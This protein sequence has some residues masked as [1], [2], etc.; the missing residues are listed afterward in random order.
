MMM[1]DNITLL[2]FLSL[3]LTLSLGQGRRRKE[4]PISD[5]VSPHLEVG[6]E[7]PKAAECRFGG[8]SYE[9]E[10]TWH[11]DLGPPFNVM[12]CVHCECVPIHKKRRIVGRVRCKNIKTECPKPTC[13]NPILL[14]GRCCKVCPG[15]NDNPDLT[16]TVD[17]EREE[18]EKNGRHYATVLT[19]QGVS[20]AATGRFYFRKKT[21]Q[22]SFLFG[23]QLGWPGQLSFLDGDLNI[24]EDFNL[25]QTSLQNQTDKLCGAW[26]R[27]PRKYRRLLRSEELSIS[28]STKYGL[29]QGKI[30]K[31]YG[32]NS[33][34]FSGLFEG[35]Y[36]SGTAIVSVSPGTGSIHA[37]I[38]FKGIAKEG[39]ENVKFIVRFHT[40]GRGTDTGPE[41]SVEESVVL[42]SVSSE[43]SSVEVRTV[44]DTPE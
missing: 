39:E 38:L 13:P 25:S 44:F 20:T 36:G 43:L 6:N 16:I 22:Y 37:N 30:K 4:L 10:Q 12:Y 18:Q 27:L 11:P 21:L 3:T 5:A 31:Y 32:L 41:L 29:I 24:L 14:P 17:L 8:E 19:G 15:Q 7:K 9:L 1:R 23:D 33:E 26:E 40:R 28:L 42:D 35:H 2:I 34:L